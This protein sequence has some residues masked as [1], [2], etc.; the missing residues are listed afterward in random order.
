V[1]NALTGWTWPLNER[2]LLSWLTRR[3]EFKN[4][5]VCTLTFYFENK[6]G[7]DFVLFMERD[8]SLQFSMPAS[9]W[10]CTKSEFS[11]SEFH[12]PSPL[13]VVQGS[14]RRS[15]FPFLVWEKAEVTFDVL[16]WLVHQ[17]R[18]NIFFPTVRDDFPARLVS[19]TRPGWA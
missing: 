6:V 18:A 11:R 15:A 7:A 1:W 17:W 10:L 14:R 16:Y 19:C 4:C 13:A 9:R 5:K 3:V 8:V 2:T 12:A